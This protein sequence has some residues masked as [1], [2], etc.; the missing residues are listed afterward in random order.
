MVIVKDNRHP[1]GLDFTQQRK[2]V[3]L[4]D[5]KHMSWDDIADPD[6]GGVVNLQCKPTCRDVVRRAY[7]NFFKP[8]RGKSKYDY[9]KCASPKL[10]T[11]R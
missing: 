4:R 2:V 1:K 10:H 9:N 11:P 6:K 3:M 8:G 7:S 5:D